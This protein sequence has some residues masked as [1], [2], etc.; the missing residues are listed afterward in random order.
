MHIAATHL[1]PQSHSHAHPYFKNYSI[2]ET[3]FCLLTS[4]LYLLYFAND[5]RK[6]VTIDD[7]SAVVYK[8]YGATFD[9]LTEPELFKAYR[10]IAW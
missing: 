1:H 3:S 4:N 10:R 9:N 7:L 2:E 8:F 6:T 5:F